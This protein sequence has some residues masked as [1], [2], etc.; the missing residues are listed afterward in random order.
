MGSYVMVIV[1]SWK[2]I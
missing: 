1:L 2:S